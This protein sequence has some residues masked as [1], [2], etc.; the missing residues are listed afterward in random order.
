[1]SR[2]GAVGAVGVRRRSLR[3]RNRSSDARGRI[4]RPRYLRK[5]GYGIV[6]NAWRPASVISL[7]IM[8]AI[9]RVRIAS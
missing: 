3:W 7:P 9:K 4:V 6:A 2:D 8:I 5:G 1:M